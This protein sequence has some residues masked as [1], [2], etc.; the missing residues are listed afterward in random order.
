MRHEIRSAGELSRIVDFIGIRD[1]SGA[2]IQE[3]VDFS[4]FENMKKMEAR[5]EFQKKSLR[6]GDPEDADSFKVREGKVGGYMR[7][8]S[9]QDLEYI[10][11][12][13]ESLDKFYGYKN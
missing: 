12:A 6:P 13:M 8:F 9:E 7:H 11:Q 1:V 10:R 4:R 2:M 3:A 5:G